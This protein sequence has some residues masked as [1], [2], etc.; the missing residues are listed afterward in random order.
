MKTRLSIMTSMALISS[1]SLGQAGS[2]QPG[3][4]EASRGRRTMAARNA[5][6]IGPDSQLGP[7]L[8]PTGRPTMPARPIGRG[9][10]RV[11]RSGPDSRHGP[12]Q[13][14]PQAPR[15]PIYHRPGA[16]RPPS[17]RP[18]HGPVFHYPRGYKYRRWGIGS[19]LPLLF[20]SAKL[21]LFRLAA[22]GARAAAARLLLGALWPGPAAGRAQQPPHRGRDLRGVPL[23]RGPARF[24]RAGLP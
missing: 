13:R 14:P 6:R 16:G 5:L 24:A 9:S 19:L 8:N 15:P 3:R 18:I 2:A 22:D 23:R 17:F 21:H 4:A 20:L 12:P 1:L 7:S 10:L 11:R